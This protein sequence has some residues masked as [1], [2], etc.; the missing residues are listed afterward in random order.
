LVDTNGWS[1]LRL[2]SNSP[3]I[4][5]GNNTS[6]T[7]STDLDGN[8]R[9]VAG[10]VDVGAYECQS[11]ALLDYFIWAQ[12]YGLPTASSAVY[13]D[14]DGD[15]LSNWQEWCCLTCP[16]NALSAL[17]MVSAA[18]AET[19]VL[20]RWESVTGLTYHLLRSTNLA[21][22]PP[23]QLLATNLPGQAGST[24]HLDTN[25]ASV[26]P[27]FYRVGVGSYIPP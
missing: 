23:F 3:C 13:A 4:N 20:V 17:R 9:I 6:V 5:A 19:N 21:A 18:P 7:T 27:L 8:P 22:W 2:Q 10:T 26:G 14:A 11:P 16:T 25:A 24:S 12:G 1:N 15:G